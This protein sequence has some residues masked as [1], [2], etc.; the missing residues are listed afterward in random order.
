[1]ADFRMATA[2]RQAVGDAAVGLIDAGAAAGHLKV[3]AGTK[4]A[5][6]NVALTTQTLLAD[7]VFS[8]P[9]FGTTDASGVATANAITADASADASGTASF[10][11]IE[12]SNGVV[13]FQGDVT[14][15]GGGGDL[16][17]ATTTITAG[18]QVSISSLTI[19]VPEI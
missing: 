9:A 11:R 19:T 3:Y 18:V 4:P 7:L 13:V 8:A 5:S 16:E 14:A 10:F 12:D 17:L 6:P 1:M 15:T 2:V